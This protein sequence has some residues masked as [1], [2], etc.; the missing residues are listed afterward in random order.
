MRVNDQRAVVSPPGAAATRS[1]QDCAAQLPD[2]NAWATGVNA[3]AVVAGLRAQGGQHALRGAS[4]Q[5]GEGALESKV[6]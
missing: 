2:I 6:C 5:G 1:C 3:H 4:A